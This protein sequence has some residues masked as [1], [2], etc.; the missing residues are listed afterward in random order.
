MVHTKMRLDKFLVKN[1]L[2]GS[3]AYL[4]L[5]HLVI[6]QMDYTVAVVSKNVCLAQVDTGYSLL[7]QIAFFAPPGY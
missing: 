6:V 3:H 7:L 4:C 2:L 1:A 5:I